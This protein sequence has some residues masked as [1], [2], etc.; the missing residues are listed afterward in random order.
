MSNF[1]V[2][3]AG[4]EGGPG[5]CADLR[6]EEL[7]ARLASEP[8]PALEVCV[9]PARHR[10]EVE[11][12]AQQPRGASH[13]RRRRLVREEKDDLTPPRAP[14]P[15]HPR[16]RR[17]RSTRHG[18][19]RTDY[20]S[21]AARGGGGHVQLVRRDGRDV[22]TLYGREGRRGGWGGPPQADLVVFLVLEEKGAVLLP[23]LQQLPRACAPHRLRQRAPL[24]HPC[25]PVPRASALPRPR[26]SLICV[27]ACLS[28]CVPVCLCAC[29]LV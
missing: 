4:E 13:R 16:A 23:E 9:G 17:P 28:A 20:T 5:V 26:P 2:S 29:V 21:R 7:R 6:G 1:T 18:A 25:R 22:S 14:R 11:A 3:V 10:D 15:P 19:H 8:R 24:R 27:S 12:P